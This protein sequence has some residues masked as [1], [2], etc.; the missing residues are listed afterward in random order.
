MLHVSDSLD[1]HKSSLKALILSACDEGHVQ[2][3][4]SRASA[5]LPLQS[6]RALSHQCPHR[7]DDM[8]SH[9]GSPGPSA[10][11]ARHCQSAAPQAW[12]YRT[13]LKK[14]LRSAK[15]RVRLRMQYILADCNHSAKKGELAQT[16]K[17]QQ[18]TH[19]TGAAEHQAVAA[20]HKALSRPYPCAS[21]S[22]RATSR[23]R[24]SAKLPS[25]SMMRA[26]SFGRCA[27]A[28]MISERRY[29]G[30]AC[31]LHALSAHP[32]GIDCGLAA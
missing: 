1:S 4:G 30:S 19:S 17:T 13:Q 8:Q 27:S 12:V 11:Y 28:K 15:A 23:A 3:H 22:Q 21:T 2:Q 5:A 10:A 16:W 25:A 29:D 18:A 7:H 26:S 20:A 32:E 24:R 14:Q 6:A 31:T 9:P